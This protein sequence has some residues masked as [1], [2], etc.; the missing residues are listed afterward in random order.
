MGV[1]C[2]L[3]YREDCGDPGHLPDLALSVYNGQGVLV[4]KQALNGGTFRMEA[5]GFDLPRHWEEWV[6][7]TCGGAR[8]LS[9]LYRLPG[10]VHEWVLARMRGDDRMAVHIARQ[11]D[12]YLFGAGR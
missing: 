10:M 11:I 1:L 6:L 5:L 3:C 4:R 9:G 7:K 8:N 2:A 12:A